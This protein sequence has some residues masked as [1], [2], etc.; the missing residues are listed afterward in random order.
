MQRSHGRNFVYANHDGGFHR[1]TSGAESSCIHFRRRI[2]DA[3]ILVN[4]T[5]NG[6]FVRDAR[7]PGR[8]PQATDLESV[9]IMTWY[10]SASCT[11]VYGA[12]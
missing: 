12:R 9:I 5:A 7:G 11:P 10:F 1:R 8:D 4:P 6:V 3:D 2:V